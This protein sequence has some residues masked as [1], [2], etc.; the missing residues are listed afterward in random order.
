M[1]TRNPQKSS[2]GYAGAI[3]TNTKANP[4]A[5]GLQSEADNQTHPGAIPSY[6]TAV[7]TD[8]F[9]DDSIGDEQTQQGEDTGAL[10]GGTHP[11]DQQQPNKGG[12]NS[13]VAEWTQADEAQ[14][15]QRAHQ[16]QGGGGGGGGNK[17]RGV[18][19]RLKKGLDG[20]GDET[21]EAQGDEEEGDAKVK[22]DGTVVE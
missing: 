15:A 3:A 9:K 4:T 1:D 13:R 2:T 20:T 6:N 22:G 14:K 12:N 5:T 19:G 21:A 17:L 11:G 10:L 7:T 18:F 8:G 16:H